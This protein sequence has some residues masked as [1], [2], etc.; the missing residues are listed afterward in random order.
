MMGTTALALPE[1]LTVEVE[2]GLAA[3]GDP[4]VAVAEPAQ[5]RT[6]ATTVETSMAPLT[7]PEPRTL[8]PH[9]PRRGHRHDP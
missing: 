8:T 7:P 6:A 1:N 3:G 2:V 5:D 4:L 9:P